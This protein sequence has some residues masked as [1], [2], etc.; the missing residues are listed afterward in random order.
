MQTVPTDSEKLDALYK[1]LV[2]AEEKYRERLKKFRG[3]PHESA[4]GELSFSELKVRE[5]F[6]RSLRDE[7]KALE[8]KLGVKTKLSP[9]F[10]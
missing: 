7:I 10:P 9:R 2:E 6:V 1:K 4:A 5:D 8:I 3:V